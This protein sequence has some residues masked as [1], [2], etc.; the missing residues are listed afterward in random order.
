MSRENQEIAEMT[1]LW[2]MYQQYKILKEMTGENDERERENRVRKSGKARTG[3]EDMNRWEECSMHSFPSW[4]LVVFTIMS[5]K[6]IW[7]HLLDI[8]HD[9]RVF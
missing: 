5:L 1:E 6:G 8:Q 9:F 4:D 2:Q 7:S 3:N